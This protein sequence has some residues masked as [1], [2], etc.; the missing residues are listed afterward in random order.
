MELKVKEI[1]LEKERAEVGKANI[2]KLRL[3]SDCQSRKSKNVI[4]TH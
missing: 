3:I 1:K 2:P 4:V